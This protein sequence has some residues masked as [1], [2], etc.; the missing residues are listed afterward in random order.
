MKGKERK[1]FVGLLA[2]GLLALGLLAGCGETAQPTTDEAVGQEQQVTEQQ[3]TESTEPTTD[4]IAAEPMTDERH[5]AAQQAVT[6]PAVETA[7]E[8]FIVTAENYLPQINTY[9]AALDESLPRVAEELEAPTELGSSL[10][11]YSIPITETLSIMLLANKGEENQNVKIIYLSISTTASESDWAAAQDY[12]YGMS[13]CLDKER[14]GNLWQAL[15]IADGAKAGDSNVIVCHGVSYAYGLSENDYT[16]SIMPAVSQ[17]GEPDKIYL[18]GPAE[19]F[20][21]EY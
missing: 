9:I 13:Y 8:S 1:K 7:E 5:L 12:F 20:A 18:E 15:A 3:P 16:I 2:V 11:S 10:L 21:E 4:T 6:A 19:G 14:P 17:D